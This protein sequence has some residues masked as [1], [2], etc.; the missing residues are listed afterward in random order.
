MS[1]LFRS[2][3][4]YVQGVEE[5]QLRQI[6]C[7]YLQQNPPLM[8]ELKL[9]DILVAEGNQLDQYVQTMRHDSTWG[10]AIEIKA[11]CEIFKVAVEVLVQA[12]QKNILFLP[13]NTNNSL[14]PTIPK[15]RIEWMG[16]HYE[17]KP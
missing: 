16:M 7:N 10:G 15:I 1:C 13:S 5:N 4:F 6:I 14:P 11:F 9:Q 12:T 2:L 3:S 8:E 17:P